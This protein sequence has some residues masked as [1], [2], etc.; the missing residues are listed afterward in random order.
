[1]SYFEKIL[2]ID[3]EDAEVSNGNAYMLGITT[4]TL[5]TNPLTISFTTPA[6]GPKMHLIFHAESKDSGSLSF[7]ESI[8]ATGGTTIVANNR[9]RNSTN[10]SA[11][12][13]FTKGAT[14]SGGTVLLALDWGQRIVGDEKSKTVRWVLKTNTNYSFELTGGSPSPGNLILDWYEHTD[15]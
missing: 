5:S 9:E 13:N 2:S 14:I 6:S 11:A 10:T 1:M 8:T 4:T 15:E 12:T 3:E 7:K